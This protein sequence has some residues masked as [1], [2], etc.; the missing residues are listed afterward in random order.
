MSLQF[1]S[2][3]N[4]PFWNML[5]PG[6][7]ILTEFFFSVWKWVMESMKST[8]KCFQGSRQKAASCRLLSDRSVWNN[9]YCLKTSSKLYSILSA[10]LTFQLGNNPLSWETGAKMA[11]QQCFSTT[12]WA[13]L[14]VVLW[15]CL[16]PS[17]FLGVFILVILDWNWIGYLSC[18]FR[19]VTFF[20]GVGL[21]C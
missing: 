19:Y 18:F 14:F 9:N 11:M 8:E 10:T 20:F 7:T 21:L 5:W 16:C 6:F 4:L 2:T 12:Y 17:E 15:T 1:H 13:S 3:N